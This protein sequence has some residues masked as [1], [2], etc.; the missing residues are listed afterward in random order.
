MFPLMIIF[1]IFLIQCRYTSRNVV[2]RRNFALSGVMK[3]WKDPII[4]NIVTK[5][6][7]RKMII[8]IPQYCKNPSNMCILQTFTFTIIIK[9]FLFVHIVWKFNELREVKK[10]KIAYWLTGE[11]KLNI[12]ICNL[13]K[14]SI[15]IYKNLLLISNTITKREGLYIGEIGEL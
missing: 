9:T 10:K 15:E 2:K 7:E 5:R 4:K 3:S 6:K 8:N 1:P 12:F 11:I 13:L 14:Y